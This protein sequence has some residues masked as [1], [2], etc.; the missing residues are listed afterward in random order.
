MRRYTGTINFYSD[1]KYFMRHINCSTYD[2]KDIRYDDSERSNVRDIFKQIHHNLDRDSV[3]DHE[4]FLAISTAIFSPC[5]FLFCCSAQREE[6]PRQVS[7]KIRGRRCSV[8]S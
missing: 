3:Q 1:L 8:Y 6:S 7:M 2:A 5:S 4:N